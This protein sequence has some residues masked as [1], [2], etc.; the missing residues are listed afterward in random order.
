MKRSLLSLLVVLLCVSQGQSQVVQWASKVI[1]FSSELT[2]IQYSAQ[3]ALGKP[4]VLPAAGQNPNA[5]TPDKPKRQEF[6][7]LG[8]ATPMQIKQVAIAESYN[9]SAL[10][11]VFAYDEAGTEHLL[12]SFNPGPS[13]QKGRMLNVM[14]ERTSYKVAAIKLQFDGEAVT[15]YFSIDAVAIADVN[16]PI[17]AD[18]AVPELLSKGLV[19]E[20]LDKNVN[21]D[22]A[23]LNPLL[24]PDGKT[25]YFSRKNH[26]ENIGG[27]TDKEDIW[28]SDLGQDGK[29]TLARNM[30]PQFNNAGPNFVNAVSSTPD[31]QTVL[32]LG[33]KYLPNGKMQAGV[34][35]S[36]RNNGSWTRPAPVQ[37]ENDYN[38]NEKANYFLSNTRKTLLLSVER[39]DTRGSRDLYVSFQKNDSTWSEPLNLGDVVNTANEE[40][41]PF[42]ASDDQTL[43]FSSNGFSGYGGADVY[44]SKRLDDTWTNW[45]EPQNMGP[46]INSKL[47]DLFFNVPSASEFAYYSRTIN[48]ENAD[49][50]RVKLPIYKSP[51]PVV[52]VKGKLI[53]AKSGKPIGAKIIYERLPDGKEI[54]IANSNTET[55]EYE[56]HLPG[57]VRYG[58][59]A[60]AAGHISS[61]QNLDLT[62][63]TKDGTQTADITLEPIQVATIEPSATITLNNIFFDIEKSTLKSDSSPEL[64]RIVDLMNKNA[65]MTIEISGHADATGPE[66]YNM[67]L[68]ETR[69]KAVSGYLVKQGIAADRIS[70]T[71]FG[72]SKPIDTNATRAGRQKNRRV[73]F[74]IIKL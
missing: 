3:Q 29:W 10:F 15:D 22:Y 17:I 1:E 24:S 70:T 51:D 52:I 50:Y 47:D 55:G 74:K 66:K 21:S 53:D 57:G 7:K 36:S 2:P 54:G 33:N 13:P 27:V 31:G 58:V 72:E 40:S 65:S 19:V 25:M 43:Y 44:M 71:F 59:R 28:Y 61:N 14:V 62:S 35:L 68:S 32:V 38:Y 48:D 6:I 39:E 56:I 11:K 69:A 8:F 64:N 41:A 20:S 34:S 12:H 9:P 73:E 5:W 23:E 42:L 67:W 46:D 49:I 16:V 26:P 30:G 18:I 63:Y 4:N 45:S 37:I 60:E